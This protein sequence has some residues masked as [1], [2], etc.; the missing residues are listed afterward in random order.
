MAV[1]G[2]G[3][4]QG[5]LSPSA[6]PG[7]HR[8]VPQIL[9]LDSRTQPTL[10]SA[11]GQSPIAGALPGDQSHPD[12]A[13]SAVGGYLVWQDNSRSVSGQRIVARR[14]D[15]NLKA[16]G[17]PFLV[18]SVNPR[19]RNTGDQQ[20]PQVAL[21]SD[22]GA[23]IVWQG[24]KTGAESIYAR[25]VDAS[26]SLVKRDIR[27]SKYRKGYQID[28]AVAT[29]AD[30]SMVIVWSSYGEDGDMLGVFGQMLS[31]NGRPQGQEF[32]INQFTPRNQ[33]TPS[34]AALAN[35]SF[36]VTWISELEPRTGGGAGIA[37]VYARIY[38][39]SGAPS[40]AGEFCV[41][42]ATNN[43]CADPVVAGSSQGGFMVAW[44]QNDNHVLASGSGVGTWVT[45]SQTSLSTNGWDIYGRVFDDSGTPTQ[46]PFV[47]NTTRYG[48]QY[49]PRLCTSAANYLAV[50]TSLG[51][52]GSR[53]GVFGQLLSS[54]GD[55]EGSEFQANSTSLGRQIQPAVAADGSGRVLTVWTSYV[56][57]AYNLD[58]FAQDYQLT[59]Q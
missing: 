27:I 34:V 42:T 58:L 29:L 3:N 30:G 33:R 21:T 11:G 28:P 55:L 44:S 9:H 19:S 57:G 31:A 1:P 5:V 53:E 23:V 54:G 2:L 46:E 37:D 24:G 41:N 38:Y 51:Q 40:E 32:Q 6:T 50:W 12:V 8:P 13:I 48:D 47:V 22:G 43:L 25:L 56:V 10:A 49:V 15:A 7:G 39:G 59:G 35:G 52:D 16:A 4:S 45:A 36:V 26:G 18:S 17:D 14:L 20:N